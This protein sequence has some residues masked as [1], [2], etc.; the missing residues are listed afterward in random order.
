MRLRLEQLN[1]TRDEIAAALRRENIGTG[2]HF[3]GIH[4]HEYYRG[5]LR[6]TPEGLPE[7]TAASRA[8]LSLPLYPTMT[9]KDLREVVDALKK[10]LSHARRRG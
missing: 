6:G 9:D 10:V 8:I 4:L 5:T 3:L 7:A 2:V 1:K